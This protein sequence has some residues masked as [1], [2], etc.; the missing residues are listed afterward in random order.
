MDIKNFPCLNKDEFAEACHYLESQYCRATLGHLRK[1]WKLRLCT[2]LDLGSGDGGNA[3]YIQVIRPIEA[4]TDTDHLLS[5]LRNVSLSDDPIEDV[6]IRG[7]DV[8]V[9]AEEAD[10]V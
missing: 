3:T 8:M 4:S 2:A 7:D 6:L 5:S 1:R 9:R 10:E